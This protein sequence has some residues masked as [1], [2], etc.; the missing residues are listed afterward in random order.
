M[1]T[2]QMPPI[3]NRIRDREET[4]PRDELEALQ[5]ARLRDRIGKEILTVTGI[6]AT[7]ELAAP[8]TLER[9]TGKARR[10]LD[11]RKQNE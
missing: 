11:K 7:V 3:E 1:L 6:R 4:L 2:V 9:F 8:H 10:V 5:L